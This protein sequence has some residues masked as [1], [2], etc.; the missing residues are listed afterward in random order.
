M[1]NLKEEAKKRLEVIQE[2]LDTA[3]QNRLKEIERKLEI[4]KNYVGVLNFYTNIFLNSLCAWLKTINS[5]V[6][7]CISHIVIGYVV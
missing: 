1:L 7:G 5:H 4:V 3:E 2:K 6:D